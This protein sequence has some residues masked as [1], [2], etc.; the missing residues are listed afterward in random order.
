VDGGENGAAGQYEISAVGPDAGMQ[1]Q[2][3]AAKLL[4]ARQCAGSLASR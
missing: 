1:G 4:Q 3:G 2:T